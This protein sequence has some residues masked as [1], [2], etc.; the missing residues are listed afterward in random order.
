[1]RFLDY[2]SGLSKPEREALAKRVG[3]S[4]AYLSQIAHGH[5]RPGNSLTLALLREC[6]GVTPSPESFGRAPNA[7]A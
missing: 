6:P 4:P 7:A 5:R 2:Y 3:T 1:M